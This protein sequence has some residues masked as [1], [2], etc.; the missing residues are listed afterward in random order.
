MHIRKSVEADFPAILAIVNDAARAYQGVIPPTG[1]T[2][3]T[4]QPEELASERSPPASLSGSLRKK[5]ACSGVMGIQDKGDV[6]LVRH[7][8]VGPSIQRKGVGTKL[9]RHVEH[10]VDKPILDWH[11]GDC[12][13]GDR[14]LSAQRIRRRP[15]SR[16]IG[17][18]RDT[19]RFRR[20]RSRLRWSLP[21]EDGLRRWSARR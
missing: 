9:L 20:G 10:L 19:G 11:L 8:Y 17:C 14:V 2:S 21:M 18:S 6:A 1:G 15:E 12:V 16:K 4:C 3:L 13:V 5:D 7:A